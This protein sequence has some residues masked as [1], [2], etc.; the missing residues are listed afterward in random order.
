MAEEI[1]QRR[2]GLLWSWLQVIDWVPGG[3]AALVGLVIGLASSCGGASAAA[4]EPVQEQ[5]AGGQAGILIDVP[6]P[7]TEAAASRLVNQ[8]QAI[9]ESVASEGRQTIVL[10]HGVDSSGGSET[11]FES[12][13]RLARAM[14]SPELR[15]LKLVCWVQ[16]ELDGHSV[17]PILASDVLVMGPQGAIGDASAGESSMDETIA[18]SYQ[19]IAERRAVFPPAVVTALVDPGAELA[20]VDNVAGGQMLVAGDELRE[21]RDAGD[22]L[23]EEVWSPAGVPLRLDANRLR[24]ARI[25]AQVIGAMEPLSELLGLASLEPLSVREVEGEVAGVLLEVIGSISSNRS[26]R[27]QSNLAATLESGETNTWLVA[28]DSH[29]GSLSD[30]ATL[31]GWFA[32]PTPP[33]RTVAGVI[34]GEARG[35][36]ALL[37]MACKPL[38]MTPGSTLGGAGSDAIDGRAIAAQEELIAQVARETRRPEALIR[39]LLN[40]DLVVYR[41][42]NRRTGRV[43]YATE[44]E[45]ARDAEDP[46]LERDRWERGERIELA[47]GLSVAEAVELGLAD[48][49]TDSLESAARRVGFAEV[50]PEVSDRTL[51]RFVERIGR[52][53]SLAFFLLFLGFVMLS[54]E[55]SA[56]GVGIPG[57]ISLLCFACFF[58]IKFL[59]GTAEWLEMLA[60]ALGLLC[61]GI[62]LFVVP[63]VGIFGIG[64]VALTMLGVVLMSQTFVIPRNVYQLEVLTRGIWVALGSAAGL[65]VGVALI[66]VMLPHVPLFRGLVMESPDAAMTDTKERL[67]DFMHLIGREGVT[68]TPLRPSGKARFDEQI[69]GV[70]SDGTAI[71]AGEP[72]RVLEVYGNRIVVERMEPS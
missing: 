39:G 56:P 23:R 57:F 22:V 15:R 71:G 55:A 45:I 44:N 2:R 59:A 11:G 38:L 26:R 60:F 25:A 30:S 36:A 17:L 33:L 72:V 69:V 47:D 9:G 14:S 46:E 65:I 62:E 8:L 35:D 54:S 5:P 42:T 7:L 12:A 18:L 43:R 49:S 52:S 53:Q 21:L 3:F 29:G 64:G 37:A 20:M 4:Q 6:V 51:V 63:G 48:G 13:L 41:Y 68:T 70:V 58:W 31:A 28:I 1:V 10:R 40:R 50:P 16:G 34:R 32:P 67:A 61:I 27:W 24:S 19:A 66:R